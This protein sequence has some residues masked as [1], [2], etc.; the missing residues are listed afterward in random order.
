MKTI[1]L[2]LF[3]TVAMLATVFS[4]ALALTWDPD[5]IDGDLTEVG[6]WTSLA[7]DQ[8]D[9]PHISYYDEGNE[10]LK[11]AWYDGTTQTWRLSFILD[12]DQ[13]DD[14]KYSSIALSYSGQPE[15]LFVDISWFEDEDDDLWH[16]HFT[17]N[18]PP[19]SITLVDGDDPSVALGQYTSTAMDD[20][21]TAHISYYDLQ[22]ANLKYAKF[23]GNGW[24][25]T[26]GDDSFGDVGKYTSIAVCIV[27]Q[28][29]V[30]HISYYDDSSHDL[31]YARYDGDKWYPTS[32]DTQGDVGLWTSIA[33][34][35]DGFP[36]ISYYDATNTRLK[37]AYWD[38]SDWNTEVVDEPDNT[39]VGQYTSI[40]IDPSN[41][42]SRISY[43]DE[44]NG[45]LKYAAWNGFGWD[46]EVADDGNGDNVGQYTSL[47]LTSSGEPRI[48][49]YHVD[50]EDLYYV[51]GESTK[52]TSGPWIEGRS[53]IASSV[54]S[55]TLPNPF[56][57]RTVIN[58]ELPVSA[59]ISCR[60]Y[61]LTGNLVKTVLDRHQAAGDH[62]V[63]WDGTDERGRDVRGGV[64][65]YRIEARH[66]DGGQ[67]G[68]SVFSGKTVVVR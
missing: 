30:V 26:T 15:V 62:S 68:E 53:S 49:Y 20:Q 5:L 25:I 35:S 36:R 14:G 67:A 64:Y 43:Y 42:H 59:R 9:F 39:D 34:D 19:G 61:D 56:S 11:Y 65:F 54:F 27:N 13:R 58:Y 32:I 6:E 3:T 45:D 18:D 24:D 37:H 17:R 63:T 31:K 44:T 16:C 28:K 50:D 1:A 57:H 51:K 41:D 46:I 10:A 66:N 7:L 48:S 40:A 55:R 21:D 2:S 23:N 22:N 12:D 33:L 47:A 38:G 60:I 4:P 8:D 52:S 29:P